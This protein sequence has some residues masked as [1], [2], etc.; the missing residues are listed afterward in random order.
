MNR[1][2]AEIK[3]N[4]DNEDRVSLTIVITPTIAYNSNFET[5]KEAKKI[6]SEI[7]SS[8]STTTGKLSERDDG[9]IEH[10]TDKW[11]FENIMVIMM[12]NMLDIIDITNGRDFL[13]D[14]QEG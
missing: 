6:A 4:G 13:K 9:Y 10:S 3:K 1:A 12:D 8:L 7:L 2:K 5:E 11:L 14:Y